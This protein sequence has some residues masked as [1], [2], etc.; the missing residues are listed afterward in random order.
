M[1]SRAVSTGTR[2]KDWKTK[3][4]RSRR[5]RVSL[6]SLRFS[7]SVSPIIAVPAVS[8]SSPAAQCSRVDFPEP[9]GPMIAVSRP[10]GNPTVT[11]SR[12]RTSVRPMP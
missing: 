12:A 3:P 4:I 2:L 9:D 8:R 1:F 11:W 6:R 7:S 10:A 5:S